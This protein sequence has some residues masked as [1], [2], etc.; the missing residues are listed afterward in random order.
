VHRWLFDQLFVTLTRNLSVE[1]TAFGWRLSFY[2]MFGAVLLL[3]NLLLDYTKVRIVVEDRRSVIGALSA[4][5]RFIGR[6]PA[7]V[8]GLYALNTVAFMALLA[9]W[10][11][12][13]PGAGRWGLSMW[14]AFLVTQLYVVVRLLMKLQFLASQTALF[15]AHLAH[16]SYTAAP[17]PVWPDSAAAEAIVRGVRL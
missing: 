8:F 9:V 11:L 4:A 1:R 2:V 13:A 12:A 5:M 10:A 6:H 16:R 17:A 3:V 15:Q 14:A 7:Q